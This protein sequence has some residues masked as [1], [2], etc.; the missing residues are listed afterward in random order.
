MD[1]S[2]ASIQPQQSSSANQPSTTGPQIRSRITVVCAE[3]KRLKLKCDRRAPCG[4]CTKRGTV[5]RCIYSPAAAEKV[6][7]H[8]LNNRL[9]Q[10]EATLA[11]V[12]SGQNTPAFQSTY[13]LAQLSNAGPSSQNQ[14]SHQHHHHYAA[15]ILHD[16]SIALSHQDLSLWLDELDLGISLP[17]SSSSGASSSHQHNASLAGTSGYIKLEPSPFEIEL[18]HPRSSTLVNSIAIDM[19]DPQTLSGNTTKSLLTSRTSTPLKRSAHLRAPSHQQFQP[20][21]QT[22]LQQHQRYSAQLSLPALSIYYPVPST[23]T[24]ASSAAAFLHHP[25]SSSSTIRVSTSPPT[26]PPSASASSFPY[27]FSAHSQSPQYSKPQITSNLMAL[28]PSLPTC[29]RLLNYAK[30]VFRVRPVPFEPGSGWVGFEKRCISFLGGDSVG[31]KERDRDKAKEREKGKAREARRARQ[32]YFSGLPELQSLHQRN[33]NLDDDGS[34]DSSFGGGRTLDEVVKGGEEEFSLPF[35][36]VMCAVLAV[37][38]HSS[39]SG[40]G[41]I[42][43]EDPAFLFA[44]SQQALGVWD[45]HTSTSGH[46]EEREQMDFLLASLIG[47]MYLMLSGS[48]ASAVGEDEDTEGANPVYPLVGKMVNAARGM[49]LG[50]DNPGRK[51]KS[52]GSAL[53]SRTKSSC[54]TSKEKETERERWEDWK[55]SIWWDIMFYD[56]FVADS[57]GQQPYMPSY[58]HTPKLPGCASDPTPSAMRAD[59]DNDGFDTEDE[60]LEHSYRHD[61]GQ[62]MAMQ[63]DDFDSKRRYR[64]TM[65]NNINS[66]GV[67]EPDQ[68]AY[69][70]ARCRL[71]QLAQTIKR[72]MAHPECC[73]GYTLDQAASLENEIRRWQSDLAPS[74]KRSTGDPPPPYGSDL[75][76]QEDKPAASLISQIHS[77]ELAFMANLLIFRVHAPFL[78]AL[79]AGPPTFLSQPA[80]ASTSPLSGHA[81]QLTVQAAQS[82]LRTAKA[83]HVALGSSPSLLSLSIP[84]SMLDFY[85]LEKMVLDSIIICANP[86]LSTKPFSASPTWTFDANAL[87]DDAISGLNLLSE[88]RVMAEPHRKIVD[89][90][91]QKLSQPGTNLLKRKHDQVD[92]TS[93][94][95]TSSTMAENASNEIIGGCVGDGTVPG[96]DG[97][98]YARNGGSVAQQQ[99]SKHVD[100]SSAF[101]PPVSSIPISSGGLQDHKQQ[102]TQ[103]YKKSD[104]GDL[105]SAITTAASARLAAAAAERESEKGKDKS[106]KHAKKS[107]PSVGIRVRVAK[108]GS[109]IRPQRAQATA[110]SGGQM[111]APLMTST[112]RTNPDAVLAFQQ[113]HKQKLQAATATQVAHAITGSQNSQAS[114]QTSSPSNMN[115]MHEHR[116]RSSSFSHVQPQQ[117]IQPL[118]VISQSMD[119]P[120]PFVSSPEQMDIQVMPRKD[121]SIHDTNSQHQHKPF[122]SAHMFEQT[123]TQPQP[124]YEQSQASFDPS[125]TSADTMSYNQVSSPFSNGSG[126]IS[127]SSSPFTTSSGHP[128]T[129]TFPSHHSTPPVFGPPPPP[130]TPATY[131]HSYNTSY[132]TNSST[133]SSSLDT[134]QQHGNGSD[135]PLM[136]IGMDPTM[137]PPALE[138]SIYDK[139]Q[140]Q[141]AMYDSKP[142]VMDMSRHHPHQQRQQH[143]QHFQHPSY[144]DGSQN[145]QHMVSVAPAWPSPPQQQQSAQNSQSFWNNG[146]GFKFYS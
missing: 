64:P 127:A 32:I 87:M 11:L 2:S 78:R 29:R 95:L 14:G 89:A 55:L 65:N 39:S 76:G 124:L 27:S 20:Q 50:R 134:L 52:S 140:Q 10:V 98:Q 46:A 103:K 115:M 13:P 54:Q 61:S 7:L 77:C 44:L 19:D 56:L 138:T 104:S 96:A 106:G 130:P 129:P 47:V 30:E 94:N 25:P 131:F 135:M 68:E 102:H 146:E 16:M 143:Q 141:H 28:L 18:T 101:S 88:L 66:S 24:S 4:S 84:P 139:S 79:S 90:L 23:G 37:G 41:F 63:Q 38:S 142:S 85:P 33:D 21:S 136:D 92:T 108:D 15:P 100:L 49:G 123:Q 8:S 22:Q 57:L 99:Q 97:G 40:Q 112:P 45:T 133:Q 118:D 12:T 67:T 82:I 17:S 60:E 107:Y 53:P 93:E 137:L 35:F 1:T 36:A 34:G 80:K 91:Y 110:G 119:H 59:I 69:F 43:A 48:S 73:C 51:S 9:M 62:G 72:R 120:L 81:A 5:E 122:G 126:A 116:S 117:Q 3:C 70:G 58:T 26:P 132:V 75:G 144:D 111:Q 128:P 105:I 114:S 74:M 113:Q 109:I 145:H 83:L 86:G 125:S 31:K 42:P 6:D 121:Y 71:T